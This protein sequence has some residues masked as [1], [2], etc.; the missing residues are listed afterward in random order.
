VLPLCHSESS[1]HLGSFLCF[2]VPICIL[3]GEQLAFIGGEPSVLLRWSAL[4]LSLHCISHLWGLLSF[5]SLL[6]THLSLL[7][8]DY[9]H[10]GTFNLLLVRGS[11]NS[12]LAHFHFIA[13]TTIIFCTF[14]HLA[15]QPLAVLSFIILSWHPFCVN[16]TQ[17]LSSSTVH[18]WR[19]LGLHLCCWSQLVAPI[20]DQGGGVWDLEVIYRVVGFRI[21]VW[22]FIGARLGFWGSTLTVMC[23]HL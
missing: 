18:I 4:S 22:N 17:P 23:Q 2:F 16:P 20:W 7:C 11:P 21:G 12:T 1:S 9:L 10:S 8:W 3:G 5:C 19:V 6:C 13:I 14:Q 15:Y